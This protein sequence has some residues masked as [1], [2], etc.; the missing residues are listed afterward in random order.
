MDYKS[1]PTLKTE[2]VDSSKRAA[3]THDYMVSME[4]E[5]SSYNIQN[6]V[7]TYVASN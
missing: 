4:M 5:N 1:H 6:D 2:A 3:T 7:G